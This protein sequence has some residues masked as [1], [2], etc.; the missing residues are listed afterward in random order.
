MRSRPA[1]LLLVGAA[2]ALL[3]AAAIGVNI[4]L[5]GYANR[6]PVPAGRL[7]PRSTITTTPTKPA[8]TTTRDDGSLSSERDD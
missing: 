1:R 2:T 6:D 7:N 3:V 4:L 5:L 8:Q